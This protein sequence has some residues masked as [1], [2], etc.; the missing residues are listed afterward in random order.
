M[1]GALGE[2]LSQISKGRDPLNMDGTT[3]KGRAFWLKA[4]TRGGGLG[5]FGDFLF[6][7][8]NRFGGG[9]LNTLAGPVFGTQ[10]PSATRL[11]IGNLQELVKEGKMRNPG[12]ELTR[13]V[14]LMTPGRSLWYGSLAMERLIFDEMQK[15]IDPNAAQAFRRIEQRARRERGQSYFSPP[16]RGLPP[17]RG[18][19]LKEIAG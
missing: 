2:Q 15:M 18:P 9:I 3:E 8:V 11:S 17:K 19:R 1:L 6:S 13:F 12:R 10:V 14:Q 5:I 16:G 7:D 4:L